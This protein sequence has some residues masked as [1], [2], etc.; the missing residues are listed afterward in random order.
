MTLSGPA[1]ST[2]PGADPRERSAAGPAGGP[3][4]GRAPRRRRSTGFERAM[5]LV[6][7]LALL[8]LVGYPIA[9]VFGQ[10]FVADDGGLTLS[11]YALL[12]TEPLLLEAIRNSLWIACG[13]VLGSF[14]VGLPLAWFTVR[15][16]MPMRRFFR[17][18]AVL[19]FAAPSFIAALGWVL[20]LGPRN[21]VLN[22][23][24]MSIFGL[25][26]S[27]FDIFTP[28]GI[29]FV[30]SL[31]LYPLVFLPVSA[32]LEGIDPALEQAA[33]SLGASRWRVLRTVTFPV[34]APALIAGSILV[35]VSSAIIFGPV[36]ILGAPTGF[37]TIPTVLLSLMQF[38]PRI[39]VAAVISVPILVIIAALLLI[40]RKLVGGRKFTVIGG[41]PGRQ[42]V[43]HLG[44]GRY[45]AVAF[46]VAVVVLSLVMPFG[47]LL[48]TSF[49]KALGRPLGWDNFTLTGN[50]EEVFGRPLIA[51]AMGNSFALA[52][53]GTLLALAVALLASWLVHRTKARSNAVIVGAMAAPLAFPGAVLGIGLIIAYAAQPFGLG[54][55]LTILLIAYTGSALP[56]TFAYV[57]AGMGQIGAE[58]EEA[59]R[60]L[61]ASWARTWRRITVPL[62]RPSL[63]AAG[64][65]NFVLLFRELEMSV[66]LYTGANP[67]VATVLY[68]LASESLYQRVG[69]LSVVILLINIVVTVVAMRLLDRKPGES[70]RRSRRSPSVALNTPPEEAA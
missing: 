46:C 32:A 33:A 50:Y 11:N 41:K 30:L 39:E 6:W 3:P 28:W 58:V 51:A 25:E 56:L 47:M 5:R 23:T 53:G 26:E 48:V 14:L 60:S 62:L 7:V 16:D 21:G 15:T 54:G 9:Q 36:A 1:T 37:Q 45:P 12:G 22:T 42:D 31:F 13:T 40:Q 49:R 68:N 63:L 69:A 44:A 55:T 67:T 38:P 18:S 35:F 34:I 17:G 66:F 19:T 52:I 29:I 70:P 2:V 27:P 20:L 59:S 8:A 61:G 65:L 24:L 43:T 64:L 4:P 57:H 10:S